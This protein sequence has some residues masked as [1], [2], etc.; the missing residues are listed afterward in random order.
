MKKLVAMMLCM[1]TVFTVSACAN[2]E[3]TSGSDRGKEAQSRE[4]EKDDTD[5]G[6][7]SSGGGSDEA[8]GDKQTG[9][10]EYDVELDKH[11]KKGDFIQFGT[12]EQDN[13]IDNG[14][15]RI[16][17]Q[18]IDIRAGKIFVMSRYALDAQP[19]NKDDDE[20]TWAESSLRA[21]LNDDFYNEAFSDKE[22]EYIQ[23][24]EIVTKFEHDVDTEDKIFLLSNKE[25]SRYLRDLTIDDLSSKLCYPTEYS[26]AKGVNAPEYNEYRCNWYVRDAAKLGKSG[27][28]DGKRG[29]EDWDTEATRDDRGIRPAMWLNYENVSLADAE[30]GDTVVFGNFKQD[31]TVT[32][33]D[34]TYHYIE[35]PV[36]WVVLDIQDGKKMLMTKN[37]IFGGAYG[38]QY[39]DGTWEDSNLRS[40]L[41][42]EFY[43]VAFSAEEKSHILETT[44]TNPDND[45]YG[46]DG[47][48]DT[49]D[50]VFVLSLPEVDKYFGGARD[51]KNPRRG[52]YSLDISPAPATNGSGNYCSWYTRTPGKDEK[53]VV[54]VDYYNIEVAGT[55]NVEGCEQ[56]AHGICI[57][58]PVIW[59]QP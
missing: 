54:Y 5:G 32:N 7:D 8:D 39:S 21:W 22:K 38:D 51:E 26:L 41:K 40:R 1:I 24:T 29:N 14:P 34:G 11:L 36:L 35:E 50:Y 20:Y 33:S 37:G 17:W 30:I 25:V 47:G 44:I 55:I 9:K 16:E 49:T 59:V 18:V 57:S 53:S 45:V 58:R 43:D 23:L 10:T 19:L 15:E 56:D 52:C 2:G 4:Q 42:S 28:I 6:S 27:F 48:N 13:V 31:H 12:Y 46:T 3:D